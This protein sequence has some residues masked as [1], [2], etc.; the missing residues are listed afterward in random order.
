MPVPISLTVFEKSHSLWEKQMFP[1][2]FGCFLKLSHYFLLPFTLRQIIDLSSSRRS[3]W[4]LVR[5][6]LLIQQEKTNGAETAASNDLLYLFL[7]PNSLSADY[8]FCS[9]TTSPT[10][11]PTID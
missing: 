3:A 1:D 6:L 4:D 10:L 7:C 5:N 11:C 8:N 9:P 2:K